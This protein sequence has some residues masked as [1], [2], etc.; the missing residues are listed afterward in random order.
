M[1]APQ[2]VALNFPATQFAIGYRAGSMIADLVLPQ[3]PV[4]AEQGTY[5]VR[6]KANLRPIDAGP[7]ADKAPAA[8]V[9]YGLSS[10]TYG[11]EYFDQKYLLSDRER[12]N[13]ALGADAAEQAAVATLMDTLL[14]FKEQAA[15]AL[16]FA[17]GSYAA[18]NYT[19]LSGTSQWSDAS[20]STPLSDIETGMAL[21]ATNASK[22]DEEL[23]VTM[24]DAV[25]RKLRSHPSVVARFQYTA[26]GGIT[27]T[28]LAQLIGIKPENLH[29]GA[30]RYNSA[31]EGQTDALSNVW[32]KHFLVHYTDP[33]P[34][35][36]DALTLGG[37][38]TKKDNLGVQVTTWRQ[39]DPPGD[40]Y[41]VAAC[42]DQK[43]MAADVGY[44]IYN[45]V[46]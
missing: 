17:T 46:A 38:I 37:T 22:M 15:A 27:K 35:G 44:L 14:L 40:Y 20:A 26:G 30:S 11:I 9:N 3:I 12:A 41:R 34:R 24:G 43:I 23:S 4:V 39:N 16:V 32:G 45:A 6:D 18:T 36:L 31:D 28:Q 42:W 1:P 13:F 5:Y 33:A 2:N 29:V 8:E 10:A 7:R 19:T 21:V 25:W